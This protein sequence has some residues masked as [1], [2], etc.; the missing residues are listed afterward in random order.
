MKSYQVESLFF[1]VFYSQ[2]TKRSDPKVMIDPKVLAFDG[3]LS[4][5]T[6]SI[7]QVKPNLTQIHFIRF[8]SS[9]FLKH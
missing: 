4:V 5:G 1:R 3:S 7:S 6:A 2:D 9:W 8:I